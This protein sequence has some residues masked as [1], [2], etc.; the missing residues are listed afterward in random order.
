MISLDIK[1]E[2]ILWEYEWYGEDFRE[3][4]IIID[5]VLSF[6]FIRLKLVLR[7]ERVNFK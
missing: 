2:D 7:D 1:N 6:F 4:N 3:R 5:E